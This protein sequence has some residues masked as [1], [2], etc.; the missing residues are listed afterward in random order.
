MSG[1][2]H[3]VQ[4]VHSTIVR[5]RVSAAGAKGGNK[6]N[7]SSYSRLLRL[8]YHAPD[9]TAAI[10]DGRHPEGLTATTLIEPLT[11]R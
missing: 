8:A 10:L 11:Y 5:A 6:A 4:M 1:T 7:R 9:I 2:A 3:L